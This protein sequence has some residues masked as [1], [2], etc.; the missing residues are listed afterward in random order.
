MWWRSCDTLFSGWWSQVAPTGFV[1]QCRFPRFPFIRPHG[2]RCKRSLRRKS[3]PTLSSTSLRGC[4]TSVAGWYLSGEGA[5]CRL[6]LVFPPSPLLGGPLLRE[7]HEQPR[8][9]RRRRRQWGGGGRRGCG[10]DVWEGRGILVGH[11]LS[12]GVPGIWGGHGAWHRGVR[13]HGAVP[14][15][16]M[17][18]PLK[19]P[20]Q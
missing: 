20:C 13:G 12:D 3:T 4:R 15:K 17:L 7:R 1:C 11:Q 6:Y 8:C 16:K 10:G 9:C 14:S 19:V 5:D 18:V 2:G